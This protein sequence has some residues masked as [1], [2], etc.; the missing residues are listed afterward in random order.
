MV[1]RTQNKKNSGEGREGSALVQ[2]NN[3]GEWEHLEKKD[4]G[5]RFKVEYI[6]NHLAA[7]KASGLK[8]SDGPLCHPLQGNGASSRY[9]LVVGIALRNGAS[10]GWK[11]KSGIIKGS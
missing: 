3:S 2:S 10:F 5:L 11:D 1:R 6:L 9:Q 8:G 4:H 7:G